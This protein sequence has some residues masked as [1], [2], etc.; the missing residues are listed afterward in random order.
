MGMGLTADH[1]RL[2]DEYKRLSSAVYKTRDALGAFNKLHKAKEYQLAFKAETI[3][4][5][6]QKRRK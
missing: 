3:E 4:Y 1:I 2:S 5:F 6:N